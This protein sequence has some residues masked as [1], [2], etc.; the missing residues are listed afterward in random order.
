MVLAEAR[1]RLSRLS[2][3]QAAA[4]MEDGWTL[5]DTRA[6]D[7]RARDG[8]IPGAVHA[9]LSVLEWRVDGTAELPDPVLAES[10]GRFVLIC[11]HGYS[12]SLA[13]A[14]LHE[15]GFPLTTDV[16]GG[17]EAWAGAGLPVLREGMAP[18]ART[19]HASGDASR[20][21]PPSDGRQES[22]DGTAPW[23]R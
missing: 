23:D 19:G 20:R 1:A 9:P 12:S 5:I 4:A 11:E 3:T 21:H 22:H 13:A 16:I 14:R 18:S 6:G 2:P 17:F 7:V 8:T 10:D 15:L